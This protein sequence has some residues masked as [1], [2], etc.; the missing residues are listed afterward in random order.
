MHWSLLQKGVLHRDVNPL[1]LMWT[2]GFAARLIDLDL[3][4]MYDE[5]RH[6]PQDI[7][8]TF[9]TPFLA[10]DL[11]AAT[12]PQP[13]L[14][15]HDLEAFYWSFV[16]IVLDRVPVKTVRHSIRA[17]Q[18]GS[19]EQ[20]YDAKKSF[21]KS[22]V[23]VALSREFPSYRPIALC[24]QKLTKLIA[25]A[26]EHLEPELGS[27]LDSDLDSPHSSLDSYLTGGGCITYE[28]F[29]AIFTQVEKDN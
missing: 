12:T 28:T 22:R 23:F 20:I 26:Y 18:K 7:P 29:S 15:R 1:N 14:Y 17:W 5:A 6:E 3:S 27:D 16:W 9:S 2:S 11:L 8:L 25:R 19:K 13:H 10:L 4:S 21:L 24:L